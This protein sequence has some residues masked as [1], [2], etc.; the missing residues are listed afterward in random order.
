MQSAL[1]FVFYFVFFLSLDYSYGSK[2]GRKFKTKVKK[3]FKST[4]T[5][6]IE[7]DHIRFPNFENEKL[8]E[9]LSI[10]LF[11]KKDK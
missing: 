11:G 6:V 10:G 5:I 4:S 9:T 3:V 1:G 2:V 7:F 8:F